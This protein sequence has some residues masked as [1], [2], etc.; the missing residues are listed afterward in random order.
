MRA[1]LT[2]FIVAALTVGGSAA[3]SYVM[4]G[5]P[6]QTSQATKAP[7][8][9]PAAPAPARA[10]TTT[11]TSAPAA[12]HPVVTDAQLTKVAQTNCAGCHNDKLKEQFGNLSLQAYDVATAAKNGEVSEKM[13]RKLRAG[14]MPPPSA[15]KIPSET[16]TALVERLE[17]KVDV[18]AKLNPN[19][20]TRAFQRLNRAEY[21]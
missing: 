11:P 8:K 18:A 10:S 5:E 14:M 4:R 21:K 16:L 17:T 7:V 15:P 20:G 12:A 1:K 6:L 9:S 19:P 3:T 13:I 2:G